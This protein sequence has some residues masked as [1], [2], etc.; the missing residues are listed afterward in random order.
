[1]AQ[2]TDW[3]DP[4]TTKDFG[5]DVQRYR[6]RD[7]MKDIIRIITA[8][9]KYFTHTVNRTFANCSKV[10]GRCLLCEKGID[11]SVKVGCLIVHV[12]EKHKDKPSESFHAIGEVKVWLFGKDKWLTLCGIMEDYDQ[13]REK[14]MTKIDLFITC[15]DAEFQKLEIRPTMK[16]SLVKKEMLS[17]YEGGKKQL[18]WFTSPA[19]MDRQKEVLGIE[20]DE[21]PQ[22]E[23][24][25]IDLDGGSDD[26]VD[27]ESSSIE[28]HM[29]KIEKEEAGSSVDEVDGLLDGLGDDSPVKEGDAPW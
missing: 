10:E 28:E 5:E 16:K 7:K 2:E 19:D 9:V 22:E 24:E 21:T 1:M 12:A 23:G 18:K 6:G 27:A 11:R 20:G 13:I 14:G 17:G 8:P 26:P 29:D 15:D 25:E 4:Q 3:G